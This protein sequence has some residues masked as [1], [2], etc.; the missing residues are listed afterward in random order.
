MRR[1]TTRMMNKALTLAASRRVGMGV[2]KYWMRSSS[3]MV[4][5]LRAQAEKDVQLFDVQV[6]VGEQTSLFSVLSKGF[7]KSWFPVDYDLRENLVLDVTWQIDAG[8][9]K[10]ATTVTIAGPNESERR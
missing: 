1:P 7:G 4:R 8:D 3:I 9:K 5:D 10:H 2:K 6:A